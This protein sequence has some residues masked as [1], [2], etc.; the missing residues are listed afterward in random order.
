[1][2]DIFENVEEYNRNKERKIMI[3]F[4]DIIAKQYK[5]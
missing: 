5:T 3:V 4:D 1:M 2:D